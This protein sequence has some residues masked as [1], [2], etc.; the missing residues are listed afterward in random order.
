[1]HTAPTIHFDEFTHHTI[2]TAEA[3][4]CN[5]TERLHP[6]FG[7]WNE[8]FIDLGHIRVY[9]HRA[10]LKQRVNVLFENTA[11][12]K[13]VHHCM[14]VEGELA[15]NFL[16]YDVKAK[17]S[18]RSFHNLFLP[19]EEY[20]LGMGSQF[21]NVHVEIARDYYINLLGDSELWSETLREKLLNNG[22][23]YPGEFKLS[24][25]MLQTIHAIFNSSLSGSLKK[26]LIEAKVHELVV[27]QLHGSVAT[28][29]AKRKANENGE[30]FH[31]IQQH[32]DNTFL[33]EHSLKSIA[34]HFGINE[35]NLKKG[36]RENFN[37]TVFDYI[38]SKRLEHSQQLLQDTNQSITEIGTTVG[39]KYPNHFSAAFKKK[40]G[41]NPSEF[42]N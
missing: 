27:L 39:Y 5:V 25:P 34:R 29:E 18:P 37:T 11:V 38:L 20:Y 21:L 4:G 32:L 23:F 17:L 19:G 2:H 41:F 10:D 35:F 22:V 3:D 40:F 8:K 31:T 7:S 9:E 26:L 16:D 12:E 13:F 6:D 28:T 14:C 1:M 33:E 36:F 42:R 24:L 30:L 15:A